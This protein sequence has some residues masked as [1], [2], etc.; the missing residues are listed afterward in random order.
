MM[1]IKLRIAHG[2]ERILQ[3]F[4][5]NSARLKKL[6]QRIRNLL[7]DHI[8]ANSSNLRFIGVGNLYFQLASIFDCLTI[9]T[10]HYETDISHIRKFGKIHK[11]LL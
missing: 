2:A 3:L 9:N 1:K 7:F 11:M 6:T 8:I 10:E 4:T 5:I